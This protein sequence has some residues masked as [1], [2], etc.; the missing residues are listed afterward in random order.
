MHDFRVKAPIWQM[1]PVP[2]A[3]G[4]PRAYIQ[5]TSLRFS[6]GGFNSACCKTW[7]SWS[8]CTETIARRGYL[9]YGTQTTRTKTCGSEIT[10]NFVPPPSRE[11]VYQPTN[12]V[13]SVALRLRLRLPLGHAMAKLALALLLSVNAAIVA[14]P[15][16]ERQP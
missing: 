12:Q 9:S 16:R 8:F 7:D 10:V 13:T 3:H 15:E 1:A 4:Y 6:F 11:F 2:S 14:V 5:A